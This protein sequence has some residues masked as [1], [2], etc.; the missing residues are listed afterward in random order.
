MAMF[1]QAFGSDPEVCRAASPITHVASLSVP[2]LVITETED[3][4]A[5]RPGTQLFR[6]A[7]QKAGAK[8][9]RFIDAQHLNHFSIVMSLARKGD[10][11]TRAAMLAF[12]RERSNALDSH[13]QK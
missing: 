7:L 9:F 10:D 3:A 2:M 13:N 12:V 5:I 1:P 4:E 11:P 6:A 8:D